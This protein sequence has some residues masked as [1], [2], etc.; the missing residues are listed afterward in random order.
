[1]SVF[2]MNIEHLNMYYFV[3][4]QVKYP[5]MDHDTRSKYHHYTECWLKGILIELLMR[6]KEFVMGLLWFMTFLD[7]QTSTG[8]N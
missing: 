6:Y 2:S 7:N 3:Q 4:K 8:W 5:L 1:M